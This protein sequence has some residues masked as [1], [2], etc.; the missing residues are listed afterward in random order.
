MIKLKTNKNFN[1]REKDQN[2]KKSKL[3]GWVLKHQ[4]Q[5]GPFLVF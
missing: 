1:K 3:K 2:K 5:R 4:Q